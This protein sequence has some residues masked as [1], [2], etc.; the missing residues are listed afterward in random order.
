M[1]VPLLVG[2][3][4]AVGVA[5]EQQAEVVAAL[6]RTPERLVDV[7]ADGLRVDAAEPGVALG[8][9]LVDADPAAGQQAPDPA[10]ARAAHRLDQHAH[11]FGPESIEVER[12]A[13][14]VHVAGVRVEALD[15][16]RVLGIRERP[17]EAAPTRPA[18][19]MTAFDLRQHVR[20]RGGA[21]GRLDLEAVVGPRVVR[22][23]DHDPAGGAAL[24]DLVR[25][26]L[27]RDR[28]RPRTPPGCRAPAAPRRPRRRSTRTRS[29]GRSR[30]RRPW[31][32][33]PPT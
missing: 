16:A 31:P 28:R 24:H 11:G 33:S 17:R 1:N 29:A 5:V 6:G 12:A 3:A 8:V 2:R 30:R 14:V 25:G 20:A 13:H 23:G 9:D 27:G 32:R 18:R 21:R 10:G 4:G 22:G 19:A 15:R 7:R 26:H